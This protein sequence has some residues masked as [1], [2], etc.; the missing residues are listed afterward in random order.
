MSVTRIVASPIGPVRLEVDDGALVGVAFVDVADTPEG[1]EGHATA[2]ERSVLDDTALWL[3]DYFSGQH[4]ALD[5][6]LAPVGTPFQQR[7]WKAL[8]SIPMGTTWTYQQLAE[9]VDNVARAVGQ[10]NGANPIGV[11]VP[12][13]RVIGGSGLVGYAGG[14]ERKAWLLRHEGVTLPSSFSQGSLF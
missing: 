9:R 6:P 10:A 11:I 1:I 4:R 5:V 8:L 7:V 2:S 14:L 3:D 12:C 13:H